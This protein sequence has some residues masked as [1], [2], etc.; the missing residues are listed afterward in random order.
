MKSTTI[1]ASDPCRYL[2]SQPFQVAKKQIHDAERIGSRDA[3]AN[4]GVSRTMGKISLAIST[5]M[6]FASP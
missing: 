2:K 1:I 4:T 3:P 5:T 6:A